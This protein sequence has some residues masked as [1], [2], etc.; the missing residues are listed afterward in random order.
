MLFATFG[1]LYYD[2]GL[3]STVR[4]IDARMKHKKPEFTTSFYPDKLVT[5]TACGPP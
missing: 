3:S 2:R 1:R 5:A 4:L